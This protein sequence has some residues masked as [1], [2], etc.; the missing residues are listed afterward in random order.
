MS[1]RHDT[2]P[3]RG[4][5]ADLF[6]QHH[7]QLLRLVGGRVT[8][9]REV[10]EDAC[11]F[12]WLQLLRYQPERGDQLLGW[13]RVVAERRAWVLMRGERRALRASDLGGDLDEGDTDPLAAAGGATDPDLAALLDDRDQLQLLHKLK[14]QQRTCLLLLGHGY[15]Y[16]QIAA[17]TGHTYTW[18]NRHVRE[19][20]Q[21]LRQLVD[22]EGGER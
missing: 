2:P 13:L 4:D 9:P 21:A 8:A 6:R 17:A 3:P 19:G 16:K 22:R 20:K 11:S 18:V 15:S 14:P 7:D 1:D 12:A 5:E 10:V